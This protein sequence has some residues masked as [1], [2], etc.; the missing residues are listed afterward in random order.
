M[1][2]P[3]TLG[4]LAQAEGADEALADALAVDG[5]TG[6]DWIRAGIVVVVA[7]IV[8]RLAALIVR[9]LV[10]RHGDPAVADLIG[11]LSAYVLVAFGLVYALEEVG[12]AIGPLLGALGIAGIALA[13]ALRDILENFV[14]GLLLQFRRPFSYGDQIISGDTE[15]TV[16]SIDARSVTVETPDGETV[17][18]PSSQVITDAIVNHTERGARRTSIAIGV[19]YGTDLARAASAFRTAAA[20]VAG[21]HEDPEVEALVTGF[22]DS[23]IDFVVRVW[24]GPS[25]ATHWRVQSDVALALDAAC[26]EAGIEIPF[27]QRV[28]WTAQEPADTEPTTP[29]E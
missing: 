27:P 18:I 14:A 9:R 11:R 13:F 3:V 20:N 22:G 7:I 4:V 2:Q 19:A 17:H 23:S 21:V 12:I 15:G 1:I 26:R 6:W 28:V 29:G 24:H 8:A 25:I 5:I 16:K 10:S